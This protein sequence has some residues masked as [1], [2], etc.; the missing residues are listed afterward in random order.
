MKRATRQLL[1]PYAMALLFAAMALG[2]R[3]MLY[4]LL[5]AS[6]PLLVLVGAIIVSAWYGGVGPGL[7]TTAICA[8]VGAYIF[9]PPEWSLVVAETNDRVRVSLFV[10]QG[11]LVSWLVG[12]RQAALMRALQEVTSR[13]DAEQALSMTRTQL[14]AI[15][16]R[17]D[18]SLSAR[19][20]QLIGTVSQLRE[21]DRTE[22]RAIATALHEDLAQTLTAASLHLASASLTDRTERDRLKDLDAAMARLTDAVDQLRV[23]SD[24]LSPPMLYDLGLKPAL[25]WLCQMIEERDGL[26]IHFTDDKQPKRLDEDLAVAAFQAI[27]V[28][29]HHAAR[30]A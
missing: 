23:I 21:T 12:S 14:N 11:I 16:T 13:R 17:F 28:A 9:V 24:E 5:G 25:A 8:L 29:L 19:T 27:R 6:A 3:C 26:A 15:T 4:P 1:M 7:L 30:V 10:L 18:D 2:F 22:R 20:S